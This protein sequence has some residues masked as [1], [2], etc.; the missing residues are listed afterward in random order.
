LAAKDAGAVTSSIPAAIVTA[1]PACVIA[2]RIAALLRRIPG[3]RQTA[4]DPDLFR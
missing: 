3:E 4:S 2:C 1:R